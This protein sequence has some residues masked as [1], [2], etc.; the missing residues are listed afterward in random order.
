MRHF[1]DI[2]LKTIGAGLTGFHSSSYNLTKNPL[3]FLFLFSSLT[4]KISTVYCVY[5]DLDF[6]ILARVQ[7][8]IYFSIWPVKIL[9]R[10]CVGP[11]VICVGL[12]NTLFI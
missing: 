2:L 8:L 7:L 1:T 12:R 10:F 3:F 9:L 4:F 5:L 6:F 11:P